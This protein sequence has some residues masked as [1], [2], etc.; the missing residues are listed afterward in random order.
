[1]MEL[2]AVD[3]VTVDP[4]AIYLETNASSRKLTR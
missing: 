4:L 3:D 2:G 1:M